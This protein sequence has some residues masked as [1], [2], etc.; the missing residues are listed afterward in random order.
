MI[1][2]TLEILFH[3]LSEH[4]KFRQKYSAAR[5]IFNSLFGV[6]ILSLVFDILCNIYNL[7]LSFVTFCPVDAENVQ[8]ELEMLSQSA[9]SNDSKSNS[10]VQARGVNSDLHSASHSQSNGVQHSG[11]NTTKNMANGL[12]SKTAFA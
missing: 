4:L 11:P 6:W 3:R 1:Y 2:Q 10:L 5:H 8:R 12:P 7:G 9:A